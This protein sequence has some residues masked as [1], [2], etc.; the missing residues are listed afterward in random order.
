VQVAER[1]DREELLRRI[2]DLELRMFLAV[3]ASIPSACQ[4]MPDTFKLMRRASFLV[5][6][7]ETLR[8]YLADLEEAMDEGQNLM[9]MKYARMDDMI[10]RLNDSPMID[11]IVEVEGRWMD[12]LAERYPLTF[13][14]RSDYAA[15]VYLRSELE[16]Y[17]GKTLE[18]YYRDVTEAMGAGRNLTEERYAYIFR[19]S[20][21]DSIDDVEKER[22]QAQQA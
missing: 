16:T 11:R 12:E 19:E 5:L 6:S 4:E 17:S 8:S 10:P 22:T 18:S 20:G 9:E 21:Y 14:G 1:S 7:D 2:V 3:Q 15:G 13:K